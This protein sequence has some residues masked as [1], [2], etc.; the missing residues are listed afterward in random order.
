MSTLLND[1]QH[2]TELLDRA[3]TGDL[4][5]IDQLFDL[6][7]PRI[8]QVVRWRIRPETLARFDASD[9]IQE[10]HQRARAQMGD[11]LRRRPMPF[12][13]WLYREAHQR[14]V[15]LERFHL[16]AECRSVERELPL[17]DASSTE[18]L[19]RFFKRP[20]S[21]LYKLQ[22]QEQAQLVR[23]CLA[24]L[25]DVDREILLLRI[26]D[27]LTNAEVAVL[28]ELNPE[29]SK[30]RFARAILKLRSRFMDAGLGM[31]DLQ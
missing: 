8:K 23:R 22:Q 10:M 4:Q 29:T 18:L 2:T 7:L 20:T 16:H 19:N 25:P 1:S 26:C 21:P 13:L 5:A 28:L 17:P 9:V 27:G 24:K 15:D 14:L 30:K 6:Y 3:A 12:A 11:Y 31:E